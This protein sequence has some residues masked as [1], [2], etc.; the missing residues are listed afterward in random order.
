MQTLSESSKISS[1]MTSNKQSSRP[2]YI[3]DETELLII[4]Q[5]QKFLAEK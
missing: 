5:I 2:D 4:G 3:D 1:S